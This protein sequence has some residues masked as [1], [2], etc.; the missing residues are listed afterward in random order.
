MMKGKAESLKPPKNS[1]AEVFFFSKEPYNWLLENMHEGV[2]IL[3]EKGS[4]TSCNGRFLQMIGRRIEEVLKC[5]VND[6]LDKKSKIIYDRWFAERMGH[7]TAKFEVT[8][9]RP[10]GEE[11][12]T[13][14][15]IRQVCDRRGRFRGALVAITNTSE[16][17]RIEDEL[18][19][20]REILRRLSRHLQFIRE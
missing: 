6:F 1:A 15:S 18:S 13:F 10:D 12:H 19:S 14:T 7:Q 2:F 16:L 3:D 11:V 20:S 9:V 8:W 4:I 17:P 5:P